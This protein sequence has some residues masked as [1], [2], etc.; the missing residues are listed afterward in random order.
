MKMQW[1][2]D[3]RSRYPRQYLAII[4]YFA[5]RK[6]IPANTSILDAILSDNV[7]SITHHQADYCTIR[8]RAPFER[9]VFGKETCRFRLPRW[10]LCFLGCWRDRSC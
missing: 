5:K 6:Q 1:I 2:L 7:Q 4:R 9:A 8:L 3:D 10:Q